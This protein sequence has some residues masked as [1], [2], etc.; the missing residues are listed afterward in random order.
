[1]NKSHKHQDAELGAV[2]AGGLIAEEKHR[3]RNNHNSERISDDTAMSGTT[4]PVTDSY[5]GPINKYSQEPTMPTQTHHGQTDGY[6]NHQTLGVATG[7]AVPE[8]ESN[9]GGGGHYVEHVSEPYADVHHGG[10]VHQ[11]HGA[12]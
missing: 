2:G 3:T 8:M 4:A 7:G 9:V 10:Y 12:L 1:M 11:S 5:G 6:G